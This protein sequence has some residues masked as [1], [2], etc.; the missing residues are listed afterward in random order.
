MCRILD[1]RMS[2]ELEELW[3]EV[4]KMYFE[5]LWNLFEETEK[6]HKT[7]LSI[8]SSVVQDFILRPPQ[9]ETYEHDVS[10]IIT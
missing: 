5:V 9:C 4:D 7:S 10:L 3:T 1:D 8:P 2:N 6:N